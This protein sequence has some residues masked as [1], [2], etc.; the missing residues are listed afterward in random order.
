MVYERVRGWTSGRSLP[1]KDFV[2]YPP[3]PPSAVIWHLVTTF[4]IFLYTNQA[5][6]TG[7][8]THLIDT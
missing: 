6:V 8:M 5:L 4:L 3:P 7:H 1:V 2:K